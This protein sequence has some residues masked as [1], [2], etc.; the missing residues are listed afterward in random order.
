MDTYASCPARVTSGNG[1]VHV[2]RLCRQDLVDRRRWKVADHCTI[3]TRQNSSRLVRERWR[4]R[5]P[6]E[7]HAAVNAM[8]AAGRQAVCDRAPAEAQRN[9]LLTRHDAVLAAREV[10]DPAIE[11]PPQVHNAAH[12]RSERRCAAQCIA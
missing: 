9:E 5:M 6:D 4:Y 3:A 8:Q 10:R 11:T 1:Y 7:E 12:R 2:S